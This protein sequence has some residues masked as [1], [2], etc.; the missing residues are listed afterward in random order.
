MEKTF[1]EFN[2]NFFV[3][4]IQRLRT[5]FLTAH[6]IFQLSIFYDQVEYTLRPTMFHMDMYRLMLIRKEVENE[7]KIF[8]YLWHIFVIF[9]A[10]IQTIWIT[11]K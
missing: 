10:N 4:V 5:L 8:K 3:F 11:S 2:G 1:D 6:N 9:G 7:T